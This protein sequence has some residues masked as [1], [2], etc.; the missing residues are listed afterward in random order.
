MDVS[1]G[2]GDDVP[3]TRRTYR[4]MSA[5]ERQAERRKQLLTAGLELF[6]TRGF[7]ETR[8]DDV[9]AEAGLTKRYFYESF[10]SLEELLFAVVEDV[11][12]DLTARVVPVVASSGLRNPRPM[13]STFIGAMLD[14][15]RLVRLL[16]IETHTGVLARQRQQ[17]IE[18]A[19]DVWLEAAPDR[20]RDPSLLQTQRLLAHAYAGAVGEVA[21]AWASGRITMSA[22][23]IIDHLE[24][25]FRRIS[26]RAGVAQ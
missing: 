3:Q 15:P 16:V 13:L 25:I 11:L 2:G 4:G 5:E 17:F 9:C 18:R 21:V 22:E 26:P 8:V 20:D 7:A 14:D 6:G 19:V 10:S 12:A 24:R 23:E 1:P